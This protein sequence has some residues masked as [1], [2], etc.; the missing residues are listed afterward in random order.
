MANRERGELRLVTP[1]QTYTLRITTNACCELEDLSGHSF[2]EHITRWNKDHRISAFRW[3]IW[4]S[5]QDQHRQTVRTPED[6]GRIID[7]CPPNDLMALMASFIQLNLDQVK[8]LIR[9]GLLPKP[10][11]KDTQDPLQAQTVPAGVDS[12]LMPVGSV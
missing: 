6:A 4:A 8:E 11:Q 7:Q 3:L 12:T 2:E 9:E 10:G 1:D 5:L